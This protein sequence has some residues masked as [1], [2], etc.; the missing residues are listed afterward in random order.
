VH[1]L[2]I[3]YQDRINFVILD[4][5]RS[6]DYGLAQ[7]MGVAAHPAFAVIPA[8][9]G[10]DATD[11]RFFGPLVEEQVRAILDDTITRFGK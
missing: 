4:Y 2:R 1:G 8:D 9:G 10:P 3:E 7:D 11:R 5:D 6:E